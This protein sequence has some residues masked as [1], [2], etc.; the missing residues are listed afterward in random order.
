MHFQLEKPT[1]LV[2]SNANTRTELHGEDRVRAIDLAFTLTGENTLLDLILPGLREHHF[3]NTA[4]KAGQEVL[5][6]VL[7]PLPNLRFPKLPQSYHYAKGERWR[8]YRFVWDWGTDGAHVDFR[9]AVL[10]NLHYELIEGGSCKLYFTVQ[11]N[12]EELSN[13][14]LY[15]ELAGLASM[16]EVF[17]QL[18]PPAELQ[19]AKKGYRAGK[20]DTPSRASGTDEEQGDLPLGDETE[21]GGDAG[22]QTPEGALAAAVAGEGDDK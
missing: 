7:I 2:C 21:D 4:L 17:I 20:P 19:P 5:P 10:S 15:G 6:G 11:Y 3:C 22:P 8:G 14:D 13:N 16:G 1:Q 18:L 9:D 12:G